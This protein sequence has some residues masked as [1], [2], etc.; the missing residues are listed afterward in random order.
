MRLIGGELHDAVAEPD[1]LGA[2]AG[3]TEED[4]RRRGVRVLLEE[5]M[6]DFPG[7]VVA[8]LV[9]ELDLAER[10]LQQL[11]LALRAPRARQLMLVEDA[12]FHDLP[13]QNAAMR[14]I[15]LGI[16]ALGKS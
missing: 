12:E 7:V 5:V 6:L 4:F 15:T 3:G 13:L 11:I 1:A 10:I 16:I 9:G 14:S 8:E 2:L